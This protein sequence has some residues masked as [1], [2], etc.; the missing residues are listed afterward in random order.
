MSSK[1]V[2]TCIRY[3]SDADKKGRKTCREESAGESWIFPHRFMLLFLLVPVKLFD[4]SEKLHLLNVYCRFFGRILLL[5]NVYHFLT[6]FQRVIPSIRGVKAIFCGNRDDT[7]DMVS[8]VV[9]PVR[10]YR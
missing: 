9:L 7:L 5:S 4:Y 2:Y 1:G 10:F 3:E 6:Y 8:K